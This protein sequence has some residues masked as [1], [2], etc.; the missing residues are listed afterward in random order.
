QGLEREDRR[1]RIAAGSSDGFR[2]FDRCA[3]ELGN[4][5]NKTAQQ[6]GRL[7]GM[8]IPA[9]VGRRVIQPE[10]RAEVDERDA[11]VEDRRRELLAVPV[12]QRGENQIDAIEPVVKSLD[13]HIR[14]SSGEMWMD[15]PKRLPSLALAEQ[16]SRR[17][18]GM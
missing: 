13:D 18:L 12:W 3:V 2:R 16:F 15:G 5:V 7:M 17:E 14:I 8:A 6:F 11:L 4:A 9:L 10:I 1:R